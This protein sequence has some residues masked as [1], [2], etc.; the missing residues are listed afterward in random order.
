M[1][2]CAGGS[3]VDQSGAHAFRDGIDQT[4]LSRLGCAVDRKYVLLLSEG[5]VGGAHNFADETA[6]VDYVDRWDHV[7]T[8]AREAQ[9]TGVLEPCGF[10]QLVE[11]TLA[12]TVADSST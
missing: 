11:T 10:E 5:L 12:K 1:R 9:G 2:V 3:V 8:L 4:F 7:F 6:Q